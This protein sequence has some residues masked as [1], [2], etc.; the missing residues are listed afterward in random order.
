MVDIRRLQKNLKQELTDRQDIL[1]SLCEFHV[2]SFQ[3]LCEKQQVA[4][5]FQNRQNI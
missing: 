3:Q 4:E 1:K 5:V 2:K